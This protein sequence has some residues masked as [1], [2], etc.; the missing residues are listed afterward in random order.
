MR[1]SEFA[2]A[3][4]GPAEMEA[5]LE[6]ATLEEAG[7]ALFWLRNVQRKRR[8][9]ADEFTR[10]VLAAA[11]LPEWI[12][13]PC[14][15]M[16]G[17]LGET[18]SN[19]LPVGPGVDLEAASEAAPSLEF[20]QRATVDE[21]MLLYRW[22]V[23]NWKPPRWDAARAVS[24]W[25]RV[26]YAET[27]QRWQAAA[28]LPPKAL[29]E[30]MREAANPTATPLPFPRF[31]DGDPDA[32]EPLLFEPFGNE[33]RV[34]WVADR[35]GERAWDMESRPADVPSLGLP[36]DSRVEGIWDGFR[37]LVRDV[38][39]WK[40][41]DLRT[42]T[43]SERRVELC[44]NF[45]NVMP[46][47]EVP[48]EG[49]Y[50]AV[51]VEGKYGMRAGWVVREPRQS[52]LARLLYV[53]RSS[54]GPGFARLTFGLPHEEGWMPLGKVDAESVDPKLLFSVEKYVR[55]NLI[56]RKGPIWTVDPRWTFELSFLRM[57]AAPKLK[58]GFRLDGLR[59]ER[60]LEEQAPVQNFVLFREPNALQNESGI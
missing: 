9:K 58:A 41:R 42:Q 39:V 6:R 32:N 60:A 8:L 49:C 20:F 29:V 4:A 11:E 44:A 25:S 26:S 15:R 27:V 57:E 40:G 2:A 47:S 51:R 7:W 38:L 14:K 13:D 1:L 36:P 21:R 54:N 18:L 37:V 12:L 33:T 55:A 46:V 31:V 17:D 28:N 45:D 48:L 53:E 5:L 59:V 24:A 56:E 35:S 10:L 52:V 22:W 50:R 19:L 30:R 3:Q 23:G 43:F 34:Q 16:A